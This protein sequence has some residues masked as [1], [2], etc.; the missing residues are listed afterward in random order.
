[1]RRGSPTNTQKNTGNSS[2]F[3]G[4][5]IRIKFTPSRFMKPRIMLIVATVILLVFGLMMIYSASSIMGLSKMGDAA[6]FLKRQAMFSVI[7][8]FIVICFSKI[9]YRS[10]Q[11]PILIGLAILVYALL[12][13]TILGGHGSH[14]ATRWISVGGI[15]FQPAE[16]CKA[17]FI[18]ATSVLL[19]EYCQDQ[20]Y[21]AREFAIKVVFFILIPLLLILAEP[22]KGTTG[23]IAIT[24]LVMAYIAGFE[25]KILFKIAPVIVVGLAV[26]SLKAGY[27]KSRIL[28]AWNPWSDPFGDG[29]QIIQGFYAFSA[30]GPF[31]LGIGNSRQK[32]AYLPEAHNDF[33]LAIVGEECG[34]IGVLLVVFCFLI[35]LWAGMKIA[36][37]AEDVTG[38]SIAA[39]SSVLLMTQFLVNAL[40][41]ASVTPM[42]GKPLPFFSYGGS[43]IIASLSLIGLILS[44]SYHTNLPDTVHDKRRRQMSVVDTPS[45]SSV[46][47]TRSDKPRSS[48]GFRVVSSS[49]ATRDT[50]SKRTDT[51]S[52]RDTR[53]S[54]KSTSYA[55]RRSK[56][57]GTDR[58]SS[59]AS[60]T[61]TDQNNR[62]GVRR[63]SFGREIR[64][65]NSQSRRS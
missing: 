27:S 14:G 5:P 34:Y 24:L 16:L 28:T 53:Y 65:T 36:K 54:G 19:K 51:A 42:T 18:V 38:S 55:T 7:G 45:R 13:A 32:Y 26:L 60:R 39:G 59:S 11:G 20:L 30:G 35:I 64:D 50:R 48:Q 46:A 6:Y 3:S 10:V 49:G 22:D 4:A 43:A 29:Y 31:G 57:A 15:R 63:N 47:R 25:T 56:R 33:I 58:G 23:I 62:S 41:V 9:D 12:L 61:Y 44:V 8:I 1:M 52:R 21:E 17:Y 2:L 37:H 40:G